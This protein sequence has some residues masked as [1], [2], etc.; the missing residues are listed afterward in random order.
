M[1]AF[2]PSEELNC[3]LHRLQPLE[4]QSHCAENWPGDSLVVFVSAEEPMETNIHA[5]ALQPH[6]PA[7]WPSSGGWRRCGGAET[8]GG[9]SWLVFVS[10]LQTRVA[11]EEGPSTEALPSSHWTGDK[12]AGYSFD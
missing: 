1:G 11:W 10:L 12:P 3:T 9:M 8:R 5:L 7:F 6:T 2:L 4:T